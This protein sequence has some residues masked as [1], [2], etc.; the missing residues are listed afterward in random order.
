MQLAL[1]PLRESE[2][3]A[4]A[5]IYWQG[6]ESKLGR[7]LFPRTKAVAF[8]RDAIQPA[9]GLAAVDGAD[10]LLGLAGIKTEE[11][12]FI[13]AGACELDAVYGPIG[14]RWRGAVL[15]RFERPPIPDHLLIDGLC[16]APAHRGHGIGSRLI[17]GILAI[18]RQ[19]GFAAVRLEVSDNNP[20]A[21]ALYT[22][23][24]FVATGTK[25]TGWAAPII[26][27]GKYTAMIRQV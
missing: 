2:R 11:T 16:V 26:G 1:R 12:A 4:A 14:G 13:R 6:F 10:R 9:A 22:R 20:R 25:S 21:R 15:D 7:I 3:S 27:F 19:K 24:G 8:L 23:H 5:E 18:A 17:D